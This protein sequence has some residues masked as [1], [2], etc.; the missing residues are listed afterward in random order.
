MAYKELDMTIS[1]D[2]LAMQKEVK[3]F[4]MEVLRPAGIALDALHD[5]SDVIS[6][7]SILWDVFKKH[8]EMDLH[9][10]AFPEE[11]GGVGE[12]DPMAGILIAEE[13]AYG[14][15][16]LALSLGCAEM[17]FILAANSQDP[18]LMEL[19]K[20]FCEDREGKLIGCWCMMEPDHGSD[21][22]L[23][24]Q[25]G[26]DDPEKVGVPSVRAEKKG[27]RIYS[28]RPESRM[29]QQRHH[30]HPRRGA[31]ESGPHKGNARRRHGH[32]PVNA[33]RRE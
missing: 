21:W 20:A 1:K 6:E 12:M 7:D 14:D 29:G 28:K 25:P 23:T 2:T 11:L 27:S 32:C 18:E 26:F 24:G 33:A 4:A 16:G 17:P 31:F 8:R 19:A 9:L 3:K 10:G 5:P 30:C 22:I 13:L 15:V